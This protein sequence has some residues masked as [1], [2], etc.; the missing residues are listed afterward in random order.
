[1]ALMSD[2]SFYVIIGAALLVA[3][4]IGL[5][6]LRRRTKSVPQVADAAR[7]TLEPAEPPAGA[8]V[9]L[10]A[11]PAAGR[12]EPLVTPTTPASE[13]RPEPAVAPTPAAKPSLA[14]GLGKTALFF[15]GAID[16]VLGGSEGEAFYSDLE[17]ALITADVG[18][19]FTEVI[20]ARLR[21]S[22]GLKV[23]SRSQLKTLLGEI[24]EA[25]L[26]RF[27]P[28]ALLAEGGPVPKT[29]PHV[30]LIVGVNGAGKTTTIGKLCHRFS[31]QGLKVFVGAGD[32][33]RAA[34]TEQLR[35]WATAS[36]AEGVFQAEGADP[37]AVAFDTVQAAVSRGMDLCL[38]DTAGR[39][40]TKHNLMEELSKV[41]RVVAK[42]WGDRPEPAP[43][44]V[45]LVVD[46]S[47]GQ[48]ALNQAREF[49]KSMGL[50]GIIITKLDG[51]AKGGILLPIMA[52]LK[53]PVLMVGVGEAAEDLI[54]FHREEF[55]AGLLAAL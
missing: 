41:R 13:G 6:L 10:P 51:S 12:P 1:M 55:I 25:E 44:D 19:S 36:G 54:L 20:I 49:H 5:I 50:T 7:S 21:S 29:K 46:G 18:V 47:T 33:F 52:E 3:A 17:E 28:H 4:I 34:A 16:R 37:A 31:H 48:N 23:P 53:V 2:I 43:H 11:E 15:Q 22:L 9:P 8:P 40:H 24:F 35:R 27:V 14:S 26:P 39:L 30:V 42:A 45:W 38:I 32:T